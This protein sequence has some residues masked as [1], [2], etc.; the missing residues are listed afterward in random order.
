[1][2]ASVKIQAIHIEGLVHF[3]Y[4]PI[5]WCFSRSLARKCKLINKHTNQSINQSI[6]ASCGELFYRVDNM[7]VNTNEAF[8][9]SSSSSEVSVTCMDGVLLVNRSVLYRFVNEFSI[10]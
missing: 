2:A 1:M 10:K 7:L 4:T 6:I 8:P 9:A 3:Y 5:T